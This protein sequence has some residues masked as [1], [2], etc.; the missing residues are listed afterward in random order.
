M[1]VNRRKLQELAKLRRRESA[2][3]L[4]ARQFAGS[5]YLLGYAVECALKACIAKQTQKHDFPD[6]VIAQKAHV[7]DLEQLLRLAG[8]EPTLKED[9]S[10]NRTLEL[11]WAI[12]KDWKETCRYNSAISAAEARDF[13]SACTSR[14]NGILAWVMTKW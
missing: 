13:Y 7:H 14:S 2:A 3:L 6:R 12:V 5:Y 4:K 11:N 1:R 9:M 10:G 8:L